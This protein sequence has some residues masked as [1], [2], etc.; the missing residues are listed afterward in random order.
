[1]PYQDG[2]GY[3]TVGYG[4]K[5]Q[6]GDAR[7]PITPDEADSLFV[8]DIDMTADGVRRLIDAPLRQWQFDALVSFS[9][10][11]GCG[12]L[13]MSTL[14]KL[15]NA[16]QYDQ[17]AAEF[18]RWN[19]VAGQPDPGVTRRRLAEAAMFEQQDYSGRP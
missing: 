7:V 4:H 15:V 8:M 6:D 1:M 14:R 19:L 18:Q 16:G 12:S 17:A 11:L 13:A 9:F 3:W 2:A 10:N 5:M